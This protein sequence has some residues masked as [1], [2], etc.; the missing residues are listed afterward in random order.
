MYGTMDNGV[1]TFFGTWTLEGAKETSSKNRDI[2]S[3]LC[4]LETSDT[5]AEAQI[6]LAVKYK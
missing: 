4:S 6:F 2:P 5:L 3:P 1:N